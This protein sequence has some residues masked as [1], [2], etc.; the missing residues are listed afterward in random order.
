MQTRFSPTPFAIAIGVAMA[1]IPLVAT[2]AAD[3]A[4]PKGFRALFNGKDLTGWYGW[5]PHTSA[6]LTGE[7]LEA[8]LKA[9]REEFPNHWRVENGELVNAGTGPYATTEEEFG[10][11]EL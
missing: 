8:N 3:P 2:K 11:Y 1:V 10:D 9:Q 4:P 7:K 5:N 6:K